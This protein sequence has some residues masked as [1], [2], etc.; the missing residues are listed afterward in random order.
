VLDLF[1]GNSTLIRSND[2]WQTEQAAAINDSTVAPTDFRESAILVT[3][4]PGLYTA[5]VRGKVDATGIGL[6][7]VYDLDAENEARLAQI[8]TRG[9]VQRNDNAL[10]GGFIIAGNAATDVLIRAIGPELKDAGVANALEDTTL[11][12]RDAD[13]ELLAQNDDWK[14]NQEQAIRDTTV[15][16]KDDREAAIL[17]SL[18]AGRYT[19]IVRG[20]DGTTGIGLVEVYVLE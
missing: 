17:R 18:S 16:P 19:A 3:L 10:I 4:A 12:L 2:D 13:G 1:D 11:E 5:K 7:E 20:K 9:N 8:S 6:V 14:S 15:P